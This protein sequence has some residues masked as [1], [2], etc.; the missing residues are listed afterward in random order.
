[1]QVF[2]TLPNGRKL[3]I[4]VEG[5]DSVEQ[6]RAKIFAEHEAA[7]PSLQRRLVLGAD[8]TLEDGHRLEEYGVRM[9]AELKLALRMPSRAIEL[10]VGGVRY[11]TVLDTLLARPDSRLHAMFLAMGQGHPPCFPPDAPAARDGIPEGVPGAAPGAAGPLPQ[12][13]SGAYLI[14]RDG[15]SFRFILNHLR[16]GGPPTLPQ[17]Q[18]ELA[19]LAIEARYFGL[20]ELAGECECPL[21]A[22]ASSCGVGFFADDIM[23]LSPDAL[24]R[25]FEQRQVNVLQATRLKTQIEAERARIAAAAEAERVR[26]E[27]ERARV[28]AEQRLRA[29]LAPLEL[30]EA[31]FI[32]LIAAGLTAREALELDEAGARRLGAS[33]MK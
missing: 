3:T 13:P 32:M 9:E 7:H 15:P 22:F 30:S 26:A 2:V 12:D 28:A 18:A 1:M 5:S 16:G 21:S 24:A 31:A 25:L 10:N 14:D 17:E 20:A 11:T 23:A 19:Q 6:L 29:G 8:T 27:E 33:W 4:E